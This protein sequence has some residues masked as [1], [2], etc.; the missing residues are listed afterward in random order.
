M[1][2]DISDRFPLVEL[3][4]AH[5][6]ISSERA[7][8]AA[9]GT[10]GLSPLTLRVGQAAVTLVPGE[11]VMVRDGVDPSATCVVDFADERAF[12]DF[13]HEIRTVVGAQ[14]SETISYERGSFVEFQ[15][16]EPALRALY[17]GRRVYDPAMVGE[18]DLTRVFRWGSDDVAD[19][20]AF[21]REHG[22]AVVTGVFDESEIAECNAEVD[23]IERAAA[24]DRPG[25]W[26]TTAEDGTA[27]AC[28]LHYTAMQSER[29]A[30]LVSD[31]RVRAL[32]DAFDPTLVSHSD[33]MNGDFA[34][35]KRP[36]A[37]SGI[38][39]LPW[40]IDCGL[41]GH[42]LMCP[43]LHIGVQL[44][45]SNHD[46]GAFQILADSHNA[47]VRQDHVDLDSWPVVT[48]DAMPGDVTLH[49]PHAMHAA[50]APRD[51]GPGR[52]TL[53]L[54]F[55]SQEAHDVIGPGRSFDDLLS[56]ASDD[57]HVGFDY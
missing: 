50:P 16:W 31:P 30:L 15:A 7:R 55:S 14:L 41:G 29:L 52:R 27:L 57:G 56:A 42:G 35:L 43:G 34:V 13:W 39:D 24:P 19:I 20:G 12:A 8:L 11:I 1:L 33:R 5:A 9:L 36:G 4:S 32:V 44:S 17:S 47:S 21:T 54:G 51:S 18:D 2:T 25:S 53:Y 37:T 40:H 38:T 28:Q 22:F 26:W 10:T 48:V 49:V 46:V 3:A 6:S 45:A 23:R